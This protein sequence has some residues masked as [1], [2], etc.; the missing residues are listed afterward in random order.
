[1]EILQL[2]ED[3]IPEFKF[4]KTINPIL[5]IRDLVNIENNILNRKIHL[6]I[7]LQNH[8][9]S[10]NIQLDD[11]YVKHITIR[12]YNINS[13]LLNGNQYEYFKLIKNKI[14]KNNIK[15]YK[16]KLV[17]KL[18]KLSKFKEYFKILFENVYENKIIKKLMNK[19][20]V[21]ELTFEY[22]FYNNI[23]LTNNIFASIYIDQILLYF[24]NH[25]MFVLIT[26]NYVF[27]FKDDIIM[28]SG[29]L[30]NIKLQIDNTNKILYTNVKTKITYGVST[31][32][33]EITFKIYYDGKYILKYKLNYPYIKNTSGETHYYKDKIISKFSRN[34]TY[35]EEREDTREKSI[36]IAKTLLNGNSQLSGNNDDKSI[37]YRFATSIEEITD[38]TC[39]LSIFDD[40]NTKLFEKEN[41]QVKLDNLRIKK[42]N[43]KYG[44]KYVINEY[45][46]KR[47]IKLFIPDDAKVVY[48]VGLDYYETFDK[49]RASYAIV[50]D[51]YEYT[52]YD[53]NLNSVSDNEKFAYS[54]VYDKKL[55][56]TIGSPVY[57][58]SFD[59]SE[60]N[61][62]G[63]G[64]HFFSDLSDLINY[65]RR[66]L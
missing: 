43:N 27:S 62:C 18:Q 49:K 55:K 66:I 7:D 14:I 15:C 37:R 64:I 28:I 39:K 8:L 51:I 16:Q 12:S 52:E 31:Y 59:E 9:K 47:I 29:E 11:L 48:P 24:K 22:K 20:F 57:P 46:E 25:D 23:E 42:Y 32:I 5:N 45:G 19:I 10:F 56:Y 44:W 17:D 4:C 34:N 61:T 50:V 33:K 38:T 2:N 35:F 6:P 1:M 36:I 63:N 41:N 65:C 26:P 60:N 40:K 58:D 54:C 21:F 3:K 30:I 53:E 13:I